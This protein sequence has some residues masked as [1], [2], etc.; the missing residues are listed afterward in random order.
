M[1]KVF[2]EVRRVEQ[3]DRKSDGRIFVNLIRGRRE[4]LIHYVIGC[5]DGQS[6]RATGGQFWNVRIWAKAVE[7]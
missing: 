5:E 7:E 1:P 6:D 3:N 4:C 2:P